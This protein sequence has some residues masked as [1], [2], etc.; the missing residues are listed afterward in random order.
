MA[1]LK[2]AEK[3]ATSCFVAL[4][5]KGELRCASPRHVGFGG[6]RSDGQKGRMAE[7]VDFQSLDASLMFLCF[8]RRRLGLE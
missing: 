5:R 7:T 6:N 3:A 4:G 8:L 2:E 1:V